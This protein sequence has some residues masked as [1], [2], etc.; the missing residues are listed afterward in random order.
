MWTH[1][2]DETS[3]GTSILSADSLMRGLMEVGSDTPPCSGRNLVQV[4][5]EVGI[6]C[7]NDL[8]EEGQKRVSILESKLFEWVQQLEE[9]Q[10]A[11]KDDALKNDADISTLALRQLQSLSLPIHRPHA[12]PCLDTFKTLPTTPSKWPQPPIML[13][14]APGTQM[15]VRGIRFANSTEYQRFPGVCA[16]CILPVNNGCELP[17][18]SLVVDFESALFVGTLLMRVKGAP[19][20]HNQSDNSSTQTSTTIKDATSYFDDK[21]RKFQVVIKGRFKEEGIPMAECVTGQAFNRAAGKLPARML[22]NAL[23][24]FISTLAPQMQA[25]LDGNQPRFLTPLVATAHTVLAKNYYPYHVAADISVAAVSDQEGKPATDNDETTTTQAENLVNF[26]VYA[27][28]EN[29]EDDVE[30][31]PSD[32][33]RSVMAIVSASHVA[34]GATSAINQRRQARKRAFNQLVSSSS[35]HKPEDPSPCFDTSKEYTFEFYQHMLELTEP[36]DFKINMGRIQVGLAKPLNGQPIQIMSARRLSE[37]LDGSSRRS[38]LSY[39]WCF[40]LW[41]QALYPYAK[42]ALQDK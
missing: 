9:K 31:P 14:P 1:D 7:G 11:R 22:V 18:K 33:I 38:S 37:G 26:S 24:K 36:D 8:D 19:P 40:D 23:I 5:P 20:I 17:G 2:D 39:L 21:K 42:A 27:G 6:S 13:R 16:G 25:D 30:E 3:S 12:Y 35:S 34:A 4:L 15:K 10:A 41:H 29:M 28:S 32:D